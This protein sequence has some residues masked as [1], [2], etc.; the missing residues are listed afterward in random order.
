MPYTASVH[1]AFGLVSADIV[2]EYTHAAVLPV[3]LP[4]EAINDLFAPM[5][6]RALATLHREGFTGD[7]LSLEWSIDLRYSR[8]VHEV[9]TPVRADTPLDA[10]GLARLVDDFEALYERKYGAGS[11]YREAGIE[12]TLFRLTARGLM[13][14]PTI[15]PA[16]LGPPD[17]SSAKIGKRAIYSEARDAMA[18]ADIYDFTRLAPGHVIAGPAVIHTPITTIVVPDAQTARM[19]A[20]RNIVIELG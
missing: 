4:P 15:E 19:D 3:P 14:Q 17:A 8:Q 16:R 9:T 5:V 11:A 12:M 7:R 2:H 10:R 20:L 1:C 18:P 13:A 6:E